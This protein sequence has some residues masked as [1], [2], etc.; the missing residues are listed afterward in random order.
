M[1]TYIN[2]SM[3][4]KNPTIYDR[5]PRLMTSKTNSWSTGNVQMSHPTVKE[6]NTGRET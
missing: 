5:V 2:P 1:Y 4:I 6:T 3:G